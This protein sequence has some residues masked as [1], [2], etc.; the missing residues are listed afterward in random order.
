MNS[1]T[2]NSP[3]GATYFAKNTPVASFLGLFLIFSVQKHIQ[4]ILCDMSSE[5]ARTYLF[6]GVSFFIEKSRKI[7]TLSATFLFS[8]FFTSNPS[9]IRLV[10]S[11]RCSH[12]TTVPTIVHFPPQVSHLEWHFFCFF[13]NN[14]FVLIC[15]LCTS[16]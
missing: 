1:I 10:R 7:L 15:F 8:Y 9:L 4:I 11:D 6:D 2:A 14:I 5:R 16:T 12:K 3:W 13:R